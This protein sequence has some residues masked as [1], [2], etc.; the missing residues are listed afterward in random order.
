ML[1]GG[2][3]RQ[4]K[5]HTQISE[6]GGPPQYVLLSLVTSQSCWAKVAFV[7]L[8]TQTQLRYY[9]PFMMSMANSLLA[10]DFVVTNAVSSATGMVLA[11]DILELKGPR[12]E[13]LDEVLGSTP[14][15]VKSPDSPKKE[16]NNNDDKNA[17]CHDNHVSP[18][19]SLNSPLNR[20]YPI[21]FGSLH[22]WCVFRGTR[23]VAIDLRSTSFVQSGMD[24]GKVALPPP[25]VAGDFH[26]KVR[27]VQTSTFFEGDV[28]FCLKFWAPFANRKR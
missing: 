1:L 22:L 23:G 18:K 16:K 13:N 15:N 9:E 12:L 8:M 20:Q 25:S 26:W 11:T 4:R 27:L 19:Q 14:V 5:N 3:L 10:K 21:C 17:K 24:C 7:S 28:E 2:T 6:F